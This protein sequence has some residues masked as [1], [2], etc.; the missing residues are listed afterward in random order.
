M[1]KDEPRRVIPE[2]VLPPEDDASG[3]G[4]GQSGS[5]AQDAQVRARVERFSRFLDEAFEIP[6]T[7]IRFGWDSLIGLIPGIGD[8]FSLLLSFYI[9]AEAV[10]LGAPRSLLARMILNVTADSAIGAIPLA[11]DL[12]DVA[13]KANRRNSRLLL[14]WM[15]EPERV[16]RGSRFRVALVIVLGL[17]TVTAVIA[18]GVLLAV[19]IVSLLR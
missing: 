8:A 6:G 14:Q 16:R 17:L 2:A 4:S 19:W 3:A 13:F 10:N 9:L 11:G 18:A 5:Q 12:F 1:T 15:G 7:S